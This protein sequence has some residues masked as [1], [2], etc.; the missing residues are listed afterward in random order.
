MVVAL[1]KYGSTQ[2]L[3]LKLVM[4]ALRPEASNATATAQGAGF[5]LELGG[6]RLFVPQLCSLRSNLRVDG[7]YDLY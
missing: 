4:K 6:T 2:S 7:K 3:S 1:H 5:F